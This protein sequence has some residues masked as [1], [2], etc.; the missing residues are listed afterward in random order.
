MSASPLPRVT[1]DTEQVDRADRFERWRGILGLT[2]EIGSNAADFHGR[3][4]S[5]YLGAMM[6]SEMSASSQSV[7]RSPQRVKADGLDH[8]VLHLTSADFDVDMGDA[9]FHVPA[10]AITLNTLSRP[11]RRHAAPENGSLILSLS[12]ELVASTLP[13]PEVFHGTVL[14]GGFSD[15]VA[16]HMRMV[17]RSAHLLTASQAD[18]L[19]RATAHI[20]AAA[21]EPTRRH[22]AEA[23]GGLESAA[24]V[25]CKR[26]VELNLSSPS[27]NAEAI[28]QAVGISR[29]TLF[30]LF[31]PDGGVHSYI[32]A[33][34]LRAARRALAV[35]D[36]ASITNIAH[37]YGFTSIAGFSRA[38]KTK[39][40]VSPKDAIDDELNLYAEDTN[41]FECILKSMI[42]TK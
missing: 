38:F 40:G 41:T 12:R 7:S 31:K 30:R 13:D 16:E 42:I 6:V 19:S 11:F 35:A 27:L 23:R 1:F 25:R 33:R 21:L 28:C 29:A 17:V 26:F 3:L 37:F 34:R 22:I 8:I 24:V 39:Y 5:T 9:R 32:Q 4:T 36:R 15:L 14:R 10:G 2:H 20:L 18:G